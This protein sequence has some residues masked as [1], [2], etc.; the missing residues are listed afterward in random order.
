MNKFLGY[1]N[2]AIGIIIDNF[3]KALI[4]IFNGL[5]NLFYSI[6]QLIGLV[7]SMGGCLILLFIFNPIVFFALILNPFILTTLVLVVGVPILGKIA[8]SYLKYVHYMATEYFYDKADYY[9][10]G[11]KK[12]FE[13]MEDYGRKYREKIEKERLKREEQRRKEQAEYQKRYG[14]YYT[15]NNF[16]DFEEFFKENFGGYTNYRG[17]YQGNYNGGYQGN[18]QGQ[19]YQNVGGSFKSQYESACDILGVSYSADKYEIRLAYRKMAKM[20]HPDVIKEAGATEM[21]QKINNAYE[22]LND[23]NIERYKLQKQ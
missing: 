15:F 5:V 14:G 22:F 19:S 9:I 17:S 1:F 4:Y 2:K 12:S 21:F 18:Y 16:D 7:F 23:K 6:R 20:Y 11:R 13:K 10:L 8:V 3:L